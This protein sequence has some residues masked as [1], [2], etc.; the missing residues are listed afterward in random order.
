M[1]LKRS[2]GDGLWLYHTHG[3][4]NPLYI[5]RNVKTIIGN[6][7]TDYMLTLYF[8]YNGI[9]NKSMTNFAVSFY[10]LKCDYE[11]I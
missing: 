11:K 10:F 3:I 1:Y 7:Y 6:F 2:D 8:G 9:M 4:A 5:N